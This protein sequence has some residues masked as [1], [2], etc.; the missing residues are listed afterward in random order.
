MLEAMKVLRSTKTRMSTKNK[1]KNKN[2][3]IVGMCHTGVVSIHCNI[4]NN[5]YQHDSRVLP[6]FV[7][8]KP[9]GQLLN[10]SPTNHI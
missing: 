8:C 10:I 9:F 7:T 2:I 5:R 6:T 1:K 3:K 4:V